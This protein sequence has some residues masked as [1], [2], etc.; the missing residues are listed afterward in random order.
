MIIG[1]TKQE[2]L[3]TAENIDLM[4]ESI[5]EFL[6]SLKMNEKNILWIRLSM[7]EM[8]LKWQS[9]FGEECAC[10]LATGSRLGR[11][12]LTLTLAGEEFDPSAG[13]EDEMDNWSERLLANLGLSPTFSYQKGT[14]R[15]QLM[16]NRKSRYP[17]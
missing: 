3:L 13:G 2:Y 16:L 12:Y 15:I 14:N 7:E 10:H 1:S 6:R 8:L 5:Q 9:H 11:P 17:V 4:S